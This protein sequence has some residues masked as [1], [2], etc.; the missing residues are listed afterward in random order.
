FENLQ[1]GTFNNVYY[2]DIKSCYANIMRDYPLPCGSPELI[3]DPQVIGQKL[4]EGKEGFV[5]FFLTRMATIKNNQIPFI[6]NSENQIKSP[7]GGRFLLHTHYCEELKKTDEN[8]GK[9]LANAFYGAVATHKYKI[10][11]Y[12]QVV[13]FGEENIFIYDTQELKARLAQGEERTKILTKFFK[14]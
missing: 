10:K 14:K 5:N 7:I 8:Q 12:S 6:P 11:K 2:I 4:K 9:M 1:V 13:F 3:T